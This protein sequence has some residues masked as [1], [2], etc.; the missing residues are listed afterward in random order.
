[1][2]TSWLALPIALGLLLGALLKL[3]LV[4]GSTSADIE[5]AAKPADAIEANK[6][7]TLAVDEKVFAETA[8][9]DAILALQPPGKN[10]SEQQWLDFAEQLD[11][12]DTGS[13]YSNSNHTTPLL[14][15]YAYI[16]RHSPETI[17]RLYNQKQFNNARLGHLISF[18]L[19]PDWYKYIW[20]VG[21]LVLENNEALASIAL[22]AG[23]KVATDLFID[24]FFDSTLGQR[25]LHI[26]NLRYALPYMSQQQREKVTPLLQ[27]D[28]YI[29]D[30]RKISRLLLSDTF[31]A[32]SAELLDI[33][34]HAASQ[35]SYRHS[36]SMASYYLDGA[37]LGDDI[38][39]DLL[40]RDAKNNAKQPTNFYC[41]ACS[42]ALITDGLLGSA[43]IEASQQKLSL[44][45][46]I[47]Y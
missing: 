36:R 19:L 46:R 21:L 28:V 22:H 45:I 11:R 4:A 14:S 7:P 31:S 32:H 43:L 37:H 26:E 34:N 13:R 38:Y 10:A 1:M 39:I 9:I 3:F 15:W 47:K 5:I 16:A 25:R 23:D 18:G 27:S 42:L 17:Y 12:I 8:D 33:L 20:D 40:I 6:Q 24:A 35:G 41:S 2:K 29:I 44:N 30:P